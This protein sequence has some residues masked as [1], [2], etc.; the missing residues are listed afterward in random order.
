GTVAV[1]L[2]LCHIAVVSPAAPVP[3]VFKLPDGLCPSSRSSRS[4]AVAGERIVYG[5]IH[6]YAIGDLQGAARPLAEATPRGGNVGSP[7]AFDGRTVYVLRPDCDADRLLAVDADAAAG[8]LPAQGQV[9]EPPC[10]V[11]RSGPGGP[12]A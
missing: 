4:L 6:G 1:S 3:R 10:P 9:Q 12:R 2:A 7:V 5:A 11:R 8:P